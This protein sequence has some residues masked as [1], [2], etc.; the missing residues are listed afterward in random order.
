LT[1]SGYEPNETELQVAT[2]TDYSTRLKGANTAV[3]NAAT[4][5]SNARIARDEALYADETGL[6]ALA[7]LVKKYVKSVFGG[8]S[9]QYRQI[10]GL[11]FTVPK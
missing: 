10:S 5:L 11:Q 7:A 2:L 9:P 3:I 6:V 4:P 8:D 1:S